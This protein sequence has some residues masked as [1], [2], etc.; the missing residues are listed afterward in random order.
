MEKEVEDKSE[1]TPPPKPEYEYKEPVYET[2]P[3]VQPTKCSFCEGELYYTVKEV[4]ETEPIIGLCKP[5][6][7]DQQF[8]SQWATT[9]KKSY[10]F[11][12]TGKH[13]EE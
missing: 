13:I 2:V 9:S 1:P 3:Q 11:K 5:H 10:M 8:I 7:S 12:W 4:Q 6:H